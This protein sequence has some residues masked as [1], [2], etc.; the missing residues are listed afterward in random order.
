VLSD[1]CHSGSAVREVID[2]VRPDVL[3]GAMSVPPPDGMRAM[4]RA[5]AQQTYEAN[6]GEYDKIQQEVVPGEKTAVGANVVLISGCQDNQTSADGKKN[7]LFTQQLL[8][9]WADGKYQGGYKKF[10]KAIVDDMPPWQS[11][12]WFTVGP[13]NLEFEKS[14]P[15]TI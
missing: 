4:P 2:A 7:G 11:P 3:K 5:V 6:K 10:H 1:S 15:F 13:H 8:K 12:N 9:V 14:R